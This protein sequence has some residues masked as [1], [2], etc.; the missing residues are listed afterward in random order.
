[1]LPLIGVGGIASADDAYAKIR[2]G[3]SLLQIYTAL[4]YEGPGL[5]NR[6]KRGLAARLRA[7]GFTSIAQAIG[8]DHRGRA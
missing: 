8:A 5:V 3:A 7:D 4:V 2:A 6:I 1:R